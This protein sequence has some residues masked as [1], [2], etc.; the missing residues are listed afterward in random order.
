MHHPRP[1]PHSNPDC[2]K[3]IMQCSSAQALASNLGDLRLLEFLDIL[4]LQNESCVHH[5]AR[6]PPSQRERHLWLALAWAT[7]CAPLPTSEQ[8]T[9]HCKA[10][11]KRPL[12]VARLKKKS[13]LLPISRFILLLWRVFETRADKSADVQTSGSLRT[14]GLRSF[15]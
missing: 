8:L 3:M 11:E 12:T 5:L 1:L 9:G 13:S 6:I 7:T 10:V 14:E 15:S 2:N 4:G